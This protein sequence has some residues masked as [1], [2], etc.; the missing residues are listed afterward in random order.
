MTLCTVP[1]AGT[2]QPP[3]D[4]DIVVVA[5][6]YTAESGCHG[7]PCGSDAPAQNIRAT[8]ITAVEGSRS[9]TDGVLSRTS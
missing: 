4:C 8:R 7:K 2:V 3:R 1:A 6:S 5:V 9:A